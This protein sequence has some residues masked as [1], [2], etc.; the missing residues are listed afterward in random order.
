MIRDHQLSAGSSVCFAGIKFDL[1]SIGQIIKVLAKH[2]PRVL[3]MLSTKGSFC[4]CSIAHKDHRMDN[5][6]SRYTIPGL[7]V[8]VDD[9]AGVQVM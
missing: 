7:Q 3:R 1:S 9:V 2:A 8:K 6:L 5:L 4:F